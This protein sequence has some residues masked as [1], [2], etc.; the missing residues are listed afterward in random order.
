MSATLIRKYR[1]TSMDEPSD[2]MLAQLMKSACAE[3]NK[4]AA[5]AERAY[6]AELS[7]L[8]EKTRR[9]WEERRAAQAE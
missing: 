8:V 4:R 5:K 2:K 3:A 7:K 6:F 9:N 1:L